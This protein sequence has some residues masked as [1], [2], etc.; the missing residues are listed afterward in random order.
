[1]TKILE[2]ISH[3][4]ALAQ[5]DNENEA[6][7]AMTKARRLM[8]K[9]N[10]EAAI[11]GASR[12]YSFRHLGKP[13]GRR[14]AWQRALANLLSEFFFVEIVIVPVYRVHEKARWSVIE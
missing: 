8:L 4:L 2:R 5:S 13:T 9:Y 7:V 12:R 14:M 6:Q 10:I 11:A 1:S 3:L